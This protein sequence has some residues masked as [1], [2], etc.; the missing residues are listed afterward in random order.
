MA[1]CRIRLEAAFFDFFIG[2]SGMPLTCPR[3][4]M[5]RAPIL[6]TDALFN[7]Y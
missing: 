7:H 3:Q 6:K 5:K 1:Y 2:A 4:R